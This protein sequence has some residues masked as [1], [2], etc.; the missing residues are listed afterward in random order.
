M[1]EFDRKFGGSLIDQVPLEPGI[2][3]FFDRSG[4]LIYVGKAI[5]LRRRLQQYRN[6]SRLRRHRK[7]RRILK[8]AASLSFEVCT[9]HREACLRELEVIQS[10]RPR[11][12]VSGAY[13]FLYPMIGVSFDPASGSLEVVLSSAPAR[14]ARGAFGE[15]RWHGSFRSRTWTREAYTALSELLEFSAH[16]VRVPAGSR[17]RGVSRS[18]FRQ[19]SGSWVG[20][21]ERFLEGRHAEQFLT[22]W[23]LVLVDNAGARARSSWVQERIRILTAFHREECR[24]LLEARERAGVAEYPVPQQMRDRIFLEARLSREASGGLERTR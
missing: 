3:R 19:V 11:L 17:E 16:R 2:Y 1:R 9:S 10:L 23:I 12:N 7:M 22:D 6:A 18:L 20:G 4:A 14:V 15:I 24:R 8:D 21:F 13:S 5:R